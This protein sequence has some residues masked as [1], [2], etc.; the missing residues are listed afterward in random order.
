[1]ISDR[2]ILQNMRFSAIETCRVY[3]LAAPPMSETA[4]LSAARLEGRAWTAADYDR[5]LPLLRAIEGG[6]GEKRALEDPQLFEV[7]GWGVVKEAVREHV[8]TG[9]LSKAAAARVIAFGVSLGALAAMRELAVQLR[10]HAASS[11]DFAAERP[12]PAA[13][14]PPRPAPSPPP[15][16][17]FPA[18]V[19]ARAA[20]LGV[21]PEEYQAH[22]R[23]A[24][25][26]PPRAAPSAPPITPALRRHAEAIGVSAEEYQAH[27]YR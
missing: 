9:A 26:A 18:F 11:G 16:P 7:W 19:L 10:A 3:A 4:K 1:L 20:Q 15:A 12:A 23:V 14:P 8:G 27:V 6:I 25:S 24:P 2:V 17:G 13:L 21:S 22:V 5:C